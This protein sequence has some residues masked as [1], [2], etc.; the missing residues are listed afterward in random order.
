MA[1]RD[2]K[3]EAR[4]RFL[5]G[6]LLAEIY[7]NECAAD[8]LGEAVAIDPGLVEAHVALGFVLGRDEDFIGM[9]EAFREAV[10]RDVAAARAAAIWEPDEMEQ[11]WGVLRPGVIRSAPHRAP[12]PLGMDAELREA[13]RLTR[14]AGEHVGAGRDAEAVTALGSALRL[15][16]R[17]MFAVA[18]LVLTCLLMQAGGGA[19][20][21]LADAEG[22]LREM[23]PGLAELLFES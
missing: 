8:L 20:D 19:A 7:S 11:L 21:A 12:S 16:P 17:S 14:L 6:N 5:L 4:A 9:V 18:L 15:D 10:S 22:V 1:G 3:R 2:N 23:E 13:G